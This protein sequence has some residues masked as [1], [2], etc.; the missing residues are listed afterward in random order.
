MDNTKYNMI[1]KTPRS[2]YDNNQIEIVN[3]TVI[4]KKMSQKTLVQAQGLISNEVTPAR[5]KQET[6]NVPNLNLWMHSEEKK[7]GNTKYRSTTTIE[8]NDFNK[9]SARSDN[10]H[11]DNGGKILSPGRMTTEIVLERKESPGSSSEED[12]EDYEQNFKK[13]K[14]IKN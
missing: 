7:E 3:K 12:T 4:Q 14:E 5:T 13:E 11:E 9:K 1:R 2:N 8:Q 10:I 6:P